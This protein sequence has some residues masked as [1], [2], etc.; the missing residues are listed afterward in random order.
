M[1]HEK[2]NH[3]EVSEY[4][5]VIF[6]S[7]IFSDPYRK[8]T[9]YGIRLQSKYTLRTRHGYLSVMLLSTMSVVTMRN[10]ELTSAR[11]ASPEVKA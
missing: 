10:S 3:G 8:K 11:F 7:L 4:H 6:I 5:I 2:G 1:R 9:V